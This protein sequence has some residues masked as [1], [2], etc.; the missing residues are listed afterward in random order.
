MRINNNIELFQEQGGYSPFLAS[1]LFDIK[2]AKV[3]I[4]PTSLNFDNNSIKLTYEQKQ[5]VQIMYDAPDIALIQGPPGTG[6]T[7]V[8]AECIYQYVKQGKKVML[9]SES[10]DAVDNALERLF[11]VPDVIPIRLTSSKRAD[12]SKYSESSESI[13]LIRNCLCVN[14]A[15]NTFTWNT[16]PY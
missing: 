9:T 2:N 4:S 14:K 12:D 16:G 6:K 1:Y 3:P 13:M 8:I 7:T 5:A 10:N 15:P 11:D